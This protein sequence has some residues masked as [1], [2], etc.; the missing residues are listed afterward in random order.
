MGLQ[1]I[2]HWTVYG[3]GLDHALE[4]VVAVL[5]TGL[6]A[7]LLLQMAGKIVQA[8]Q[9]KLAMRKLVEVRLVGVH[10]LSC[11]RCRF[12]YST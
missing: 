11:S 12:S 5:T 6:A 1:A 3:P 10:E 9:L 8:K 2:L 4:L 7:T